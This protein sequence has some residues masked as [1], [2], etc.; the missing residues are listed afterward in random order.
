[1]AKKGSDAQ[2][3]LAHAVPFESGVSASNVD[4]FNSPSLVFMGP[5]VGVADSEEPDKWQLICQAR[6][7]KL[8]RE[9]EHEL[10]LDVHSTVG[11]LEV[12]DLEGR[13][14]EICHIE[15]ALH[16]REAVIAEKK[17]EIELSEQVLE[18][19]EEDIARQSENVHSLKE[20]H[21]QKK[22]EAMRMIDVA[23]AKSRELAKK[24]LELAAKESE[25]ERKESELAR[26]GIRAGKERIRVTEEII[27]RGGER[28]F[29]GQVRTS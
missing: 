17:K 9:H 7:A 3:H 18:A 21:E 8:E 27:R 16:E 14:K 22:L 10:E 19:K 4:L 12:Q 29:R 1:M 2:D 26:R 25:L 11:V 28:K 24:V 23:T 5:N 20:K 15:E 6:A 13:I